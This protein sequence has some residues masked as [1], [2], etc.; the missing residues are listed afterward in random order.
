MNQELRKNSGRETSERLQ[1]R[2]TYGLVNRVNTFLKYKKTSE[3]KEQ[4][5]KT[6]SAHKNA[7]KAYYK[8]DY[9]SRILNLPDFTYQITANL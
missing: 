6:K 1:R 3:E 7:L 2:I 9:N 4:A 8:E 5:K